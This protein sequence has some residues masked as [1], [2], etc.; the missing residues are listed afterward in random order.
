VTSGSR[1][2]DGYET[3]LIAHVG[4]A[5]PTDGLLTKP[6]ADASLDWRRA[7]LKRF[8]GRADKRL[9]PT[10]NSPARC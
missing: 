10:A 3:N 6:Y 1:S 9:A 7:E 5:F 8:A 2:I 4:V